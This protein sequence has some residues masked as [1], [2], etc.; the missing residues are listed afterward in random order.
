LKIYQIALPGSVTQVSMS[1]AMTRNQ[2]SAK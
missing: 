2:T 1:N